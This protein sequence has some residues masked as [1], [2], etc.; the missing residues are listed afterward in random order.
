[1]VN[2]QKETKGRG[3]INFLVTLKLCIQN[4]WEKNLRG[5]GSSILP[6]LPH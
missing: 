4:K 2:P 1:M 3:V 6:K 5:K